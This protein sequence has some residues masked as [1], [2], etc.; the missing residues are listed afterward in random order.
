MSL[1]VLPGNTDHSALKEVYGAEGPPTATHCRHTFLADAHVVTGP[2]LTALPEPLSRHLVMGDLAGESG[3][4]LLHHLH[5][6]QGPQDLDVAAWGSK[7]G[8][9]TL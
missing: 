4:L 6:L 8:P 5:I 7:G 9:A 1:C 2:K 3:T